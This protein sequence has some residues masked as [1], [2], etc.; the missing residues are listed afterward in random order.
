MQDSAPRS[1]VL[2]QVAQTCLPD[3]SG[4]GTP[5]R[6]APCLA[7]ALDLP[8]PP[9]CH[10]DPAQPELPHGDFSQETEQAKYKT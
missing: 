5:V 9:L 3:L 2:A 4:G 8:P 1:W 7:L 10:P 6:E